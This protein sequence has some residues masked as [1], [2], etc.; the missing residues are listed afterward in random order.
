MRAFLVPA[1]D[2]DG[3][4]R[5]M[6]LDLVNGLRHSD[7]HYTL[8][9]HFETQDEPWSLPRHEQAAA[10]LP[11][12]FDSEIRR[13]RVADGYSRRSSWCS[14]AYRVF[15]KFADYRSSSIG[16]PD[17][18]QRLFGTLVCIHLR[19]FYKFACSIQLSHL[20][21]RRSQPKCGRMTYQ[22]RTITRVTY[23]L[24]D[25]TTLR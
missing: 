10:L 15:K 8:L 1:V 4:L 14:P 9:Y 17:D 21:G 16:T 7:G 2:V 12:A 19:S 22:F 11:T 20:L 3:L 6:I 18:V 23:K 24:S 5:P 25:R 13:G